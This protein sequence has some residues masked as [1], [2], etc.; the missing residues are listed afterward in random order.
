MSTALARKPGQPAR[1]ERRL[2]A[3]LVA[4]AHLLRGDGKT[5]QDR[6]I[7]G[8]RAIQPADPETRDIR[9]DRNAGRALTIR[10]SDPRPHKDAARPRKQRA[11]GHPRLAGDKSVHAK[12]PKA[13]IQKAG[14]SR[15]QLFRQRQAQL[16]GDYASLWPSD[17]R[18]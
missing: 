14:G 13:G 2:R 16:L 18:R 8:P 3:H 11:R 10:Q 6:R 1:V 9:R 5:A 12:I 17:S 7:N 15:Y 4:F